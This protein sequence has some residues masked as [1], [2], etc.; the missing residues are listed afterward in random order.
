M[1]PSRIHAVLVWQA[2]IQTDTNTFSPASTMNKLHLFQNNIV[3]SI[4]SVLGDFV[5][6]TFPGYSALATGSAKSFYYF[7]PITGLYKVVFQEPAGGWYWTTGT[8]TTPETCYGGYMTDSA[9]TTYLGAVLLATPI[10]V[11]AAGIGIIIP[12]V[13]IGFDPNAFTD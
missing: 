9:G 13:G 12:E 7:D 6:S 10:L 8:P 5:E 2:V 11:N 1:V 4:D 3:P